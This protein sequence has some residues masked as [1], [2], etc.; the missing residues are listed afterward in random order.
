MY[1][2][3][4]YKNIP[5]QAWFFDCCLL[6]TGFCFPDV[7]AFVAYFLFLFSC[8][9]RSLSLSLLVVGR[10]WLV[11]F[12]LGNRVSDYLPF[13]SCIYFRSSVNFVLWFMHSF[14]VDNLCM[15]ML[16]LFLLQKLTREWENNKQQLMAFTI[17]FLLETISVWLTLLLTIS[18]ISFEWIMHWTIEILLG[19]K[20]EYF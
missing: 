13:H 19:K 12:L 2:L 4:L 3:L 15:I 8:D 18:M 17:L 1:I 7:F 16:P 9:M 14:K 11:F 20:G 10:I 5:L 6:L